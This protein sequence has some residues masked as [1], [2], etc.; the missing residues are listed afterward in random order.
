MGTTIWLCVYLE[1]SRF[2]F[3]SSPPKMRRRLKMTAIHPRL[4]RTGRNVAQTASNKKDNFAANAGDWALVTISIKRQTLSP[5]S[6]SRSASSS[7][8]YIAAK[9]VVHEYHQSPAP[10]IVCIPT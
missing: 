1:I 9:E 2:V 6:Q 3:G 10:S 4:S 8:I 5:P 7:Y